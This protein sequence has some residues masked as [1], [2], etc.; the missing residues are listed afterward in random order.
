MHGNH[1]KMYF[2]CRLYIDLL[3]KNVF[4]SQGLVRK[5]AMKH[6]RA[7]G[8]DDG[9]AKELA[10]SCVSQRDIQVHKS[11]LVMLFAYCALCN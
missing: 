10:R 9:E 5:F 8:M 4:E 6:Y 11:N 1:T 7:S 2:Y 3:S